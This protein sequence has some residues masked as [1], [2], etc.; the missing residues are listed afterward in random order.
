MILTRVRAL[1]LA[2]LFACAPALA[3]AQTQP[4][5][6]AKH[7]GSNIARDTTPTS[8]FIA[9]SGGG[10]GPGRVVAEDDGLPVNC[11][12]GCAGSAG[13]ATETTLQAIVAAIETLDANI[14]TLRTELATPADSLPPQAPAA[15]GDATYT[16]VGANISTATDTALITATAA[17]TGRLH[18]IFCTVAGAQTITFKD[19]A[20]AFTGGGPFNFPS[21]GG[22]LQWNLRAHPYFATS[23]NTALNITTTTTAA[24]SCRG[25]A[26]K[27]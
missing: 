7:G 20:S 15:K 24:V 12:A 1:A 8:I 5:P 16:L 3:L 17:Q 2:C 27:D 9:P 10:Y 13:A 26:V 11:I 14:T 18:S 22:V 19:G 4:A 21:G 6:T 23:A 25:D